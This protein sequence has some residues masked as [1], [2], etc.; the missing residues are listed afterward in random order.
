MNNN[1]P[2][3]EVIRVNLEFFTKEGY[4]LKDKQPLKD[5]KALADQWLSVRFKLGTFEHETA[6]YELKQGFEL[7]RKDATWAL[8]KIGIA[9][10][11][12]RRRNKNLKRSMEKT[13]AETKRVL[14]EMEEWVAE[15]EDKHSAVTSARVLTLKTM[16]DASEA[17]KLT[18]ESQSNLVWYFLWADL[19]FYS[20]QVR[21]FVARLVF[22]ALRQIYIIVVFILAFGIGYSWLTGFIRELIIGATPQ[23]KWLGGAL[24]VGGYFI[25]KYMIDPRLKKHQVRFESRW[26]KG[27]CDRLHE[28]RTAVLIARTV[29]RQ[30]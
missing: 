17:V 24:L 10:R 27:L 7:A 30:H 16:V 21:Y 8:K 18:Y 20:A 4:R 5:Y 6:L 28:A 15:A 19:L 29:E 3:I 11:E 23:T 13:H 26:L 1:N 12:N 25:K 2:F 22:I 14:E 9:F